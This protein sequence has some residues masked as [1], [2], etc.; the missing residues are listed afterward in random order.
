MERGRAHINEGIP[1]ARKEELVNRGGE[2]LGKESWQD[3]QPHEDT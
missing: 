1:N 3:G 2:R